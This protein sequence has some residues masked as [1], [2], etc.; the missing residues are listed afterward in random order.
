VL[1]VVSSE[2]ASLHASHQALQEA[3]AQLRQQLAGAEQAVRFRQVEG[4]DVRSAYEGLATEHRRLQSGVM[5]VSQSWEV[6]D[7]DHAKMRA[8]AA[9]ARGAL[10]CKSHHHLHLGQYILDVLTLTLV[11]LLCPAAVQLERESALREAALASAH[12]E[13]AALKDELRG[14]AAT[15]QQQLLELAAYERQVRF[16]SAACFGAQCVCARDWRLC[17][18]FGQEHI[19]LC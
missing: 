17:T 2:L 10:L 6:C 14:Q 9:A 7:E 11:Y 18:W 19:M 13:V 3:A 5:Q 1:Q 8:W 4:E 16:V 15:L 12:D